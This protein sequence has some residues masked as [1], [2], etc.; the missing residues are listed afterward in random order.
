MRIQELTTERNSL[1]EKVRQDETELN[2]LSNTRGQL[3]E[4]LNELTTHLQHTRNSISDFQTR[5]EENNK[6]LERLLGGD[7]SKH[8]NETL[9]QAYLQSRQHM[10]RQ[11]N[12][13]IQKRETFLQLKG[14][15]EELHETMLGTD[16]MAATERSALDVW[17]RQYNASHS[18][19]QYTELEQFFGQDRDWTRVREEI[20]ST[21]MEAKLTQA[22]VDQLRSQMVALQAEGNIPDGDVTDALLALAKQEEVLEKRRRDAMLQIATNTITLQAHEKAETLIK[23]EKM[24]EN[25]LNRNI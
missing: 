6:E 25:T 4:R 14:R 20:R 15:E 24:K 18:P 8:F 22:K 7:N 3:K 5:Q 11:Q 2:L 17:I 16:A 1:G 12:H 10:E 21:D 19:V 9:T 23:D 13:T